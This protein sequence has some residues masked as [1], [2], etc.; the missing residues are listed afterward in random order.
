M[1]TKIILIALI[2]G[3][4]TFYGCENGTEPEDDTGV[5]ILT[6][7]ISNSSFNDLYPAVWFSPSTGEIV[8][9]GDPNDPNAETPP[10]TKYHFWIEPNDPEFAAFD[11]EDQDIY[12]V[13]FIGNGSNYFDVTETSGDGGFISDLL[14]TGSLEMDNVFYIRTQEGDCL[15]QI[16]DLQQSENYLKFKWKKL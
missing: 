16:L 3:M 2:L 10:E 1:K 9:V 13:K 7:E 11:Y 5:E 14:D 15:I 6:I 12:G 8:A 4:V